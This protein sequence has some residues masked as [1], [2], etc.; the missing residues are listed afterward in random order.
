MEL[1]KALFLQIWDVLDDI[2]ISWIIDNTDIK[3]I[4]GVDRFT[5]PDQAQE[6]VLNQIRAILSYLIAFEIALPTNLYVDKFVSCEIKGRAPL[7]S[8]KDIKHPAE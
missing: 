4:L 3:I 7:V 1:L 5:A 8:I 2:S 6:M